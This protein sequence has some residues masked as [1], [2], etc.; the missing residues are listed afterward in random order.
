MF[1]PQF[2]QERDILEAFP[3][4]VQKAIY[5]IS[6]RHA[7]NNCDLGVGVFLALAA[8]CISGRLEIAYD[9]DW[10]ERANLFVALV[11]E[12]GTAKTQ[13]VNDFF[14]ELKKKNKRLFLEYK[15]EHKVYEEEI[16]VWK[17]TVGK[18]KDKGDQ[19]KHDKMPKRPKCMA[20]LLHDVTPE[21]MLQEMED[22]PAG[23]T[24]FRDELSNMFNSMDQYKAKGGDVKTKFISGWN[25]ED[26][27][28]K[29]KRQDDKETSFYVESTLSLIGGV[30]PGL[31][32]SLFTKQDTFQ[33]IV[34]RMIFV[35]GYE[36]K[37]Q[38][39]TPPISQASKNIISI[40][41][42]QMTGYDFLNAGEV[43]DGTE[44]PRRKRCV[45]SPAAKEA[46]ERMRISVKRHIEA[47]DIL[48]GF[49]RKIDAMVLRIA[50]ILHCTEHICSAMKWNKHD[51]DASDRYD[52]H[53]Y[54]PE[55][56]ELETMENALV[57]GQWIYE[58]LE[59]TYP[60]LPGIGKPKSEIAKE[61]EY[62]H[63]AFQLWK[64][65]GSN[66]A[67]C[68]EYHSIKE[69][70][71]KGYPW[72]ELDPIKRN[73]QIGRFFKRAGLTP[74]KNNTMKYRLADYKHE[75]QRATE[76][77]QEDEMPRVKIGRSQ[78]VRV[79]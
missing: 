50:L 32:D 20:Y 44:E 25:G 34:Q 2:A 59:N 78:P 75:H 7:L 17:K 38:E 70:V 30:Q 51:L 43:A 48:R 46:F 19:G 45:L 28:V 41:T 53:S 1:I 23:L 13:V 72:D 60:M 27:Q 56:V 76:E 16:Y 37:E 5:E 58:Q 54:P 63:A 3:D 65:V 9:N 62:T 22:N 26:D 18:T 66:K 69:I 15:A 36:N 6:S 31:I 71:E 55:A 73:A 77:F 74:V 33:G 52:I 8:G 21:A 79:Q 42:Q 68:N 49:S 4:P 24:L 35:R 40:L 10:T 29:R 11:A 64:F 14:G 57:V 61:D 39:E 12:S 67:F 47:G